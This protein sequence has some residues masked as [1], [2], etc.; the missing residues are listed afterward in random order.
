MLSYMIDPNYNGWTKSVT[1]NE[2]PLLQRKRGMSGIGE[3][4]GSQYR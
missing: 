3:G 2:I 1:K 4:G